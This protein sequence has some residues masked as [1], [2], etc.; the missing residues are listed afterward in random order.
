MQ[1]LWT[2]QNISAMMRGMKPPIHP[3]KRWLFEQQE[4]ASAFGER[5]SITQSILSDIMAWKKSPSLDMIGR[6]QRA[7]YGTMQANDFMPPVRGV[8]ETVK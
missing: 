6:I 4:T 3:L 2:R 1:F 5:A 8:Q 7:T